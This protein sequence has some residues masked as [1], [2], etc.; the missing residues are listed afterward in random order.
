MNQPELGKKINEIRTKLGITQKDLS[1][2]CH[3]DIRT[4]QRIEAGE[5][6]PRASTIKLIAKALDIEPQE[7]DGSNRYESYSE[8]LRI[9]LLISLIMG[10]I[11]LMDWFFYIPLFPSNKF[12]YS[13]RWLLSI[14][15]VI[16]CVFFYYGFKIIAGYY[17]CK[18]LNFSSTFFIVGSPVYFFISSIVT[19]AL[20]I[21]PEGQI[22]HLILSLLG[23][24]CIFF[25]VGLLKTRSPFLA[26]YKITGILQVLIAPFFILPFSDINILGCWI[27]IPLYILM[28]CIVYLEYRNIN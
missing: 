16:S 15:N 4:I 27:N 7:L 17:K 21:N 9:L 13:H 18:L 22:N 25:G 19:G 3:V 14:I 26:L 6:Y 12:S 11:Y 8:G 10:I 23:I 1:E 5:V 2:S 24:N 28:I 20:N